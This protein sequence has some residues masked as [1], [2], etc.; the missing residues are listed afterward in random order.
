MSRFNGKTVVITGAARGQGRAHA[1][2][3]ARE[4]ANVVLSDLSAGSIDSV[5][6][7]LGQLS[8]LEHTLGLVQA[9]GATG[10]VSTGDT[11]S[12]AVGCWCGP[13]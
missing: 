11:R 9:E 3:F 5:P 7:A 8:D 4:G 1:V 6:Y 10:I 12:R 13:T 2:A